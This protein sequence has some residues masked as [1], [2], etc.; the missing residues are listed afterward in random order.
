MN[1]ITSA[2]LTTTLLTTIIS[3]SA[4]AQE[5]QPSPK[6]WWDNISPSVLVE[7]EGFIADLPNG[8]PSES[9]I[10]LATVEFGATAQI[11]EQLSAEIIFLFEEDETDLEI[12]V[13]TLNYEFS[14]TTLSVL[15]G[16]TYLP[17]G[18]FESAFISDPLTLEIGETRETAVAL[19]HSAN[20]FSSTFFLFNGDIDE[21]GRNQIDGFGFNASYEN[22]R[23]SIG[24]GYTSALGDS[25]T[26]QESLSSTTVNEQT[27]GLALDASLNLGNVTL[28][29]EYVTA[30]D[31]FEDSAL[32]DDK[33]SATNLELNY[34]VNLG[35]LPATFAVAYQTTDD[36][37]ALELPE[38]R[39]LLGLGLELHE[40]VGLGFEIARDEDYDINEGGTGDS[41]TIFSI[42]L[43]AEF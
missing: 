23:F 43:A 26:L 5:T 20:G 14:G 22:D 32:F 34:D 15:A 12:D 17:F 18:T 24:A 25:D 30:L 13:A 6:L 19:T 37:L 28:I 35:K 4:T 21:D 41:T 31:E 7:V 39:T 16:Q 9:D 10:F 27:D 33:P 1:T 29:A 38:T 36:S 11:T 8:E 40:N 2:F 3:N 42:Q